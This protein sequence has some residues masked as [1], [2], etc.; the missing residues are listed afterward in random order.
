MLFLMLVCL[1]VGWLGVPVARAMDFKCSASNCKLPECHCAGH[2]IPGGLRPEDVPQVVLITFD[3]AVNWDNWE[4]YLRLFPPDGSRRNPNGC[5]IGATFFVSHNFSDYCMVRKL[6][7]GGQEIADHSVT[8][9]LPHAWWAEANNL[10]ISHEILT[11]RKNLADLAEI[12]IADIKGWRSPFLQPSGDNMF[13]VLHQHNFTYDATMTYPFP[14]NVYSP[15]MWPFTLDYSYTLVCNIQPCPKNVYPGFWIVP[16]VVMMDYREHLPCAY[17]D[18]CT[19]EPRNQDETFEML[20]KNFLRNYRTNRAPMYVN[21]HSIWLETGFH[22]DAM[23]EFLLRL[24]TMKDVFVLPIHKSLDW[25]RQPTPLAQIHDFGPWQCPGFSPNQ[26]D[27]HSCSFTFRP[28]SKRTTTQ[29]PATTLQNRYHHTSLG[30]LEDRDYDS[31]GVPS[32]RDHNGVPRLGGK[33]TLEDSDRGRGHAPGTPGGGGGGRN[34]RRG[35]H[36]HRPWFLKNSSAT[37][38]G[39]LEVFA[40]LF[41]LSVCSSFQSVLV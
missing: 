20:W 13:E 31:P 7:A 21:L 15:V 27:G 30:D 2:S 17:L 8:H 12:P 10:D 39:F 14:R 9:R 36:E 4:L 11:Q 3:D 37:M 32:D 18:H 29:A 24:G 23:D 19:N 41:L 38:F 6:H 40:L 16:V 35:S 28:R 26:H 5:P 33:T 25:V 1:L 34:G 22:L